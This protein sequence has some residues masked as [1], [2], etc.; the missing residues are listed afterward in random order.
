MPLKHT[1]SNRTIREKL[2]SIFGSN[3]IQQVLYQ[4]QEEGKRLKFFVDNTFLQRYTILDDIASLH[5]DV[6]DEI[7]YPNPAK[8]AGAHTTRSRTK[9]FYRKLD[10]V[11]IKHHSWRNTYEALDLI[12][13]RV[14]HTYF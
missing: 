10:C 4:L 12:L 8:T 2:V 14:L 9:K 5:S 13:I 3:T 1:T 11:R 7:D 6:N